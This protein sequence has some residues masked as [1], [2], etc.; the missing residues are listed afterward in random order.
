M[1]SE[2]MPFRRYILSFYDEKVY[3]AAFRRA[4]LVY[5]ESLFYTK[6][7]TGNQAF[8]D[9]LALK[10]TG[11][12]AITQKDRERAKK[13]AEGLYQQYITEQENPPDELTGSNYNPHKTL[14]QRYQRR[15]GALKSAVN[16]GISNANEEDLS[17]DPV[18]RNSGAEVRK[19]M[20]KR[21][22]ARETY[23]NLLIGILEAQ[24]RISLSNDSDT[25][26]IVE[27]A[28]HA[29]SNEPK[30]ARGRNWENFTD[31]V[32]RLLSGETLSRTEVM[33]KGIYPAIALKK[34]K[35]LIREY[36]FNAN[37]FPPP[38]TEEEAADTYRIRGGQDPI[39]YE[40]GWQP[41][42]N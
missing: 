6:N 13:I 32:I 9:G 10:K 3:S 22:L 34:A 24:D 38:I 29:L 35:R 17:E 21:K 16:Q 4:I 20:M 7:G 25:K 12:L 14:I 2:V 19:Q 8:N 31:Y 37:R 27:Y 15:F 5:G 23:Q 28:R 41:R 36:A 26:K 39:A 11:N 40:E 42:R 18:Y 1:P 30:N 33:G